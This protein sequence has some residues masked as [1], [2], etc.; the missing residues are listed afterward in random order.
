[1]QDS[2]LTEKDGNGKKE[3]RNRIVVG[4]ELF[5]WVDGEFE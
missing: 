1:M 4:E 2:K 3:T 5:E